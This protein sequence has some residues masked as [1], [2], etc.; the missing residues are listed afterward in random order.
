MSA[1]TVWAR[2][3]VRGTDH[4]AVKREIGP[5][6]IREEL[7]YQAVLARMVRD[8][9]YLRDLAG[10]AVDY[11][12]AGFDGA[13]ELPRGELDAV[14]GLDLAGAAAF[15]AG[16]VGRT[17]EN[18]FCISTE[19]LALLQTCRDIPAKLAVPEGTLSVPPSRTAYPFTA[20]S[21][22]VWHGVG[23][24]LHDLTLSV[25]RQR[26]ILEPA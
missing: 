22:S 10:E 21:L 9:G 12:V 7:H 5:M 23:R 17:E 15:R 2:A 13:G 19:T 4:F 18:A 14:M 26:K 6:I 3:Y 16:L 1:D 11:L 8:P 24:P 20:Y 25:P